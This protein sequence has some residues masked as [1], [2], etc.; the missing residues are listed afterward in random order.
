MAAVLQRLETLQ[1]IASVTVLEI[2]KILTCLVEIESCHLEE[3]WLFLCAS[4]HLF[5][6]QL[7]MTLK[8]L[9]ES[10]LQHRIGEHATEGGRQAYRHLE[11]YLVMH[12]TV[13]HSQHWK[14]TFTDG[15]EEPIFLKESWVF[16]MPHKG[17]MGIQ[18]ECN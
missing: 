10:F 13:E 12:K 18:D 1:D 16:R 17:E 4:H 7:D 9:K 2:I 8:I 3:L 14:I 15:F 11:L 6:P 5:L